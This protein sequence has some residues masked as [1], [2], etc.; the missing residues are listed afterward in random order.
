MPL[1]NA[2]EKS[3][4]RAT[5]TERTKKL[6]TPRI[7]QDCL[8]AIAG[9]MNE[10]E[11]NTWLRP[12]SAK[13][14]SNVLVLHAPN[15]HAIEIVKRRFHARIS[16]IV[17]SLNGAEVEVSIQLFSSRAISNQ[18]RELSNRKRTNRSNHS[19]RK[20]NQ[21]KRYG[22]GRLD[23]HFTFENFVVGDSN[24]LA[25]YTAKF[26]SE[27]PGQREYN[28]LF[29]Y[30][31]VGNGKTHLMQAIGHAL[32]KQLPDAKVAYVRSNSFVQH[33]V[34]L[35]KKRDNDLIEKFKSKY[36]QLDVLLIDDIHLFAGA[37]A[38]QEEFFHTFNTLLEGQKQVVITSDRFFKEI[39]GMEDRLISRFGQGI[40][41][42]I[43]PPEFETRVAILETKAKARKLCLPREISHFLAER[44]QSNVRELEGAINR[45][46]VNQRFYKTELT[47]DVVKKNLVDLLESNTR[48]LNA[49]SIQM[50]VANF[51][52][53]R[54]DTMLSNTRVKKI[55]KARHIA[56]SLC[57]ELTNESL[58]EIGQAFRRRHTTVM[59]ARKRIHSR[60]KIDSKLRNEYSTLKNLL[61]P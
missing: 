13:L 26:T 27:D 40:T 18:N 41:V 28:P 24:Q 35:F 36:R 52:G 60:T 56:M 14:E 23:P 51:Y 9:E 32:R 11:F 30:G 21:W 44:I 31:R 37:N 20:K 53:I 55:V 7:W 12:L 61:S 22:F 6:K 1:K 33:L 54:V 42:K 59:H 49:S 50:E 46:S 15:E 58:T 8:S 29:I 39:K 47:I 45:L 17:N 2:L 19:K 3:K 16:E 5:I 57:H 10:S 48:Q 38:S 4:D 25:W 43:N 34:N